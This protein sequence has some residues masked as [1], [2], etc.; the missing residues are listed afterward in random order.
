MQLAK[1]MTT[2]HTQSF[3]PAHYQAYYCEENIWQLLQHPQFQ[4]QKGFV[5]L[6]LPTPPQSFF[7]IWHQRASSDL[8][9]P[10]C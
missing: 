8:T 1:R 2:L 3:Q 6:L 7:A 10:L 5:L 9:L 4:Q